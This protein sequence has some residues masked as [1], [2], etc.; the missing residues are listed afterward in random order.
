M[1]RPEPIRGRGAK[2]FPLRG[3]WTVSLNNQRLEK[4]ALDSGRWPK[5]R[6]FRRARGPRVG[7]AALQNGALAVRAAP[8]VRRHRGFRRR[9]VALP[10]AR[11]RVSVPV[12]LDSGRLGVFPATAPALDR[13]RPFQGRRALRHGG[14]A[15]RVRGARD[16]DD[17]EVR[18]PTAAVRRRQ[19]RSALQPERPLA[20]RAPEA[21][22]ALHGRAAPDIGPQADI[23][24]PDMAT[25]EQTM[26]W[27]MDT[28]SMQPGT[29]CPRS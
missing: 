14:H 9:T 24:A 7:D 12:H 18:T 17:L 3:A 1:F 20:G 10:G 4:P 8:P 16:V 13:A 2:G 6:R 23:P 19:G 28:Y 22:A 29:R 5:C 15:R 27:M 21:D 25:N 26:A 11:A